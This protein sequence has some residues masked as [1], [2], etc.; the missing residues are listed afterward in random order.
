MP[1]GDLTDIAVFR[2]VPDQPGPVVH[3]E[4]RH[5]AMSQT[6]DPN[7]A[8][9]CIHDPDPLLAGISERLG[10]ASAG[11]AVV[12][13]LQLDEQQLVRIIQ[14]PHSDQHKRVFAMCTRSLDLV[15]H[16]LPCEAVSRAAGS[17]RYI[18]WRA[19]R[20]AQYTVPGLSPLIR[21]RFRCRR[22][23]D[24]EDGREATKGGVDDRF[25][26]KVTSESA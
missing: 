15:R 7:W 12:G 25:H 20:C 3:D 13:R 22:P 1:A 8:A 4:I 5:S 17:G 11:S 23:G 18:D 16:E 24:H 14:A 9:Q 2:A 6:I 26:A 10:A 19:I 21:G